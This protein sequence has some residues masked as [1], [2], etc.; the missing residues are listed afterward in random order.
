M[1]AMQYGG[2]LLLLDLYQSLD[3]VNSI[4]SLMTDKRCNIRFLIFFNG[5]MQSGEIIATSGH[6]ETMVVAEIDYSKI[7]LQR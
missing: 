4:S 3:L 6:E 2:T 1:V 7:E 5:N